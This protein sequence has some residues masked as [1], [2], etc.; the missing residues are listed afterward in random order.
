ME[1]QN[2]QGTLT[3]G[4]IEYQQIAQECGALENENPYS[5]R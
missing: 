4:E 1:H 5:G 2:K 3:L